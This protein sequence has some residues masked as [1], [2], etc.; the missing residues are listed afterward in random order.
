MSDIRYNQW[1]HN[2]GTGGV[3]QDAGGNIGIGTTAPLI[4]VG[5]GNTAILNVGVVTCNSIEVTGNVSVGGT[6][7][8]QD[9]TNI[10]SV[11]LITARAGIIDSTLTATHVAYAGAN[12]RLTGSANLTFNGSDLLI[13]A[14]TNA[15]KGVKFDNSF[16]L[17]FGSSSG[18]SPRLYLKG[19]SNSQSDAGDT[20]LATGT[21][22]EQIFRSNTFTKFEVNADNTTAEALRIASNG[23]VGVNT[24]FTGS[25]T[26][27]NGQRL[28][29]FGGGGNVTGE[30]HLGANRGDSNQS[31]GSINF[32]DNSQDSTHRHIALI[33]ADKSGSTSNKRGGDLIFFTKKDNTAAPNERL[34]IKS[35]GGLRLQKS[36]GNGNFTISRNASVTSTDQPIG[37][38]DF[39]SNTAHTVQA[40]IMGKTLGTSNV[41]GDLVV[42]TRADGGSLD[43]RFRI[44]GAGQVRLPINGQELAMGASQQF[45]MFW[46][47]SESR[48]YLKCNG[49]YGL[50]F[51][52][53][54]GNR[55]EIN[56]TT[57]DVTMQGASGRN[58]TWDNS[59][60]ELIL[61]DNGSGASARLKI[62]SSGDLQMYHDVSGPN[63]ITCSTNQDLKVSVKEL[64]LYDYSGVS[65]KMTVD[66][67]GDVKLGTAGSYRA[68]E[69][70]L[71]QKSAGYNDGVV[72]ITQNNGTVTER[73]FL[74]FFN[75]A[76]NAA[77]SVRH[78]GAT[79]CQ[80]H[81]SSDYRLKE[82]V[83]DIADGISRIKQL[84]PRRFNFK[85]E[86][87]ETVDGFLAHEVSP[88]I[89]DAVSGEKD[90][91]VMQSLG[92]ERLTPLLTAALKEAIAKIETLET[93]VAALEGS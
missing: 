6:L 90:G 67:N 72:A 21:G 19:T 92:Y 82:N 18:S 46:E 53:N 86:P 61:T 69:R 34:R 16:N 40:R 10:D 36:D 17:T 39:A 60:A 68:G 80:Y 56:G 5:A 52:I 45:R 3:S 93:K 77:G 2:S 29:I 71:I 37:V 73:R 65:H 74:Y 75:S 38:V 62:G 14:S 83:V 22:G 43:E 63:H 84:K 47:N 42:E 87:D 51:R 26:W 85:T 35:D 20:F 30:L 91:E 44:T 13:D 7:T 57:G 70:I 58:F 31:V 41:G 59:A 1:L 79:S 66:S 33:E 24:D 88:V 50:A 81:T 27:R 9:V 48:Q 4:P 89:P 12:G 49:A 54:N 55:L 8:Y 15:Y 25:Q 23:N 76:G 32:F 78:T 64:Q 28:E 11:G